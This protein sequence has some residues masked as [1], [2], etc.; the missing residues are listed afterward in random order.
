MV[1]ENLPHRAGRFTKYFKRAFLYHWNLLG[2]LGG[3]GL[4]LVTS[5][6]VVGP[7]VLAA[8]VAYL[9]FLGTHPKFQRF[10][11]AQGA[12]EARDQQAVSGE[13]ALQ[14]IMATLPAKWVQR[15]EALRSRCLELRGIAVGLKDPSRADSP[16]PLEELQLAGLD[17]LLWTFLRLL[18]TQHMLERFF[19]RTD[20]TLIKRDI[21][22]LDQRLKQPA[23]AADDPQKQKIR[24]ALEDN[25]ETSRAR[26]ANLQKARDN[27]ELVQLEIDRLENKISSLSEL[28]VNRQEP[29]FIVRQVD[30]VASSMVQTERT[31]NELQFATGLATDEAVPLL[32]QREA[33]KQ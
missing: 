27:S 10:V 12:R 26:L 4:A 11:E 19:E 31:M 33:V 21:E 2:F 32:V 29:D 9:G 18:F 3:V 17:R 24:K 30:Q 6:T 20:E 15:F 13:Q 1:A 7:L 16:L 5:P 23:G 25:R 28:G 14:R 22:K 8:E